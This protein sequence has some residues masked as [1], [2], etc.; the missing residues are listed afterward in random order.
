MSQWVIIRAGGMVHCFDL[1]D[2]APDGTVQLLVAAARVL[3]GFPAHDDWVADPELDVQLT[4]GEPH[5]TL[6]ARPGMRGT[7]SDLMAVDP[8]AIAD[9]QLQRHQTAAAARIAAVKAALAALDPDER[10]QV[11]RT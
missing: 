5:P 9:H 4:F 3:V 2:E 7:A 8:V 1:G 11:L 6:L 10:A